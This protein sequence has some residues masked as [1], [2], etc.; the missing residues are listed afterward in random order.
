MTLEIGRSEINNDIHI[1]HCH[2]FHFFSIQKLCV[3]LAGIILRPHIAIFSRSNMFGLR[4]K[5]QSKTEY[6]V[7]TI[8]HFN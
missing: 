1:Y 4:T 8:F 2:V 5:L 3:H 6:H 7:L